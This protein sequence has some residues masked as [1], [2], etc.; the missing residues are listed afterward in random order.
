[1]LDIIF[2]VARGEAVDTEIENN[3]YSF[4][5][6]LKYVFD[7][8]SKNNTLYAEIVELYLYYDTPC[9]VYPASI[10]SK[11][12]D[13][14]TAD[15]VKSLIDKYDFTQKNTWLWH[16]YVELPEN[17]ITEKHIGELISF[18]ANPPTQL[19]SAGYRPLD[20]IKKFTSVD[21]SI[22]ENASRT[23][24]ANYDKCPFV[25]NLYEV[26]TLYFSLSTIW[27]P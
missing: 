23:I 11:L 18:F 25:F 24:L 5:S 9:N 26:I 20:N 19:K 4:S 22:F 8:V 16:F 17:Q 13:F 21:D 27:T 6:G 15:E 12:F 2:A 1:M 7:A 3:S 10:L 14:M